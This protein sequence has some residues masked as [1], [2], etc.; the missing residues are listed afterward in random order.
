MCLLYCICV[1]C[2]VHHSNIIDKMLKQ[3]IKLFHNFKEVMPD[4]ASITSILL[5]SISNAQKFI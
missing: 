5:A 4:R 3:T 2:I 1:L